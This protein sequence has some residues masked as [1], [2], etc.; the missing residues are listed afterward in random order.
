MG[1]GGSA[2][3]QQNLA[4]LEILLSS[5]STGPTAEG[6]ESYWRGCLAVLAGHLQQRSL[7]TLAVIRQ[8]EYYLQ[9]F[10]KKDYYCS[11]A[12]KI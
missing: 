1:W 3:D 9:K 10:E 11:T 12:F 8:S 6:D 2:G 5:L 4:H 7:V